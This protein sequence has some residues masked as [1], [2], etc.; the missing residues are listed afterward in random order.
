M[1]VPLGKKKQQPG[2]NSWKKNSS[3]SCGRGKYK[4]L[5]QIVTLVLVHTAC[6]TVTEKKEVNVVHLESL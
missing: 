1:K 5:F 3:C 2:L 6:V 4:N